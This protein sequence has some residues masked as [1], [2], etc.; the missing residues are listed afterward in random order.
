[1]TPP[2]ATMTIAAAPGGELD[3]LRR[4]LA[5]ARDEWAAERVRLVDAER[6][7]RD[8]M[9]ALDPHGEY[10]VSGQWLALGY[11]GPLRSMG[12]GSQLDQAANR[13][14]AAQRA[15]MKFDS[16]RRTAER[17]FLDRI[18]ALE[19]P[20]REAE[21]RRG[22]LEEYHAAQARLN[23][24]EAERERI[25]AELTN[26]A[27]VRE[28]EKLCRKF[29][30][31]RQ[32]YDQREP[33]RPQVPAQYLHSPGSWPESL[34]EKVR[35]SQRLAEERDARLLAEVRQALNEYSAAAEA[36]IRR[37]A[38]F[39]QHSLCAEIE[40]L[41]KARDEALAALTRDAR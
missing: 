33:W 39:T 7:A 13:F 10:C 14:G 9:L 15:L 11:Q 35:A 37:Q 3:T 38:E 18:E 41:R 24:A 32:T 12:H 5:A 30:D 20:L 23:A 26:G 8:E 19:K 28:V 25:K 27:E 2:M 6:A 31:L 36:L 40:Q 29:N 17:S 22:L 1:M 21:C 34:T 16:E 4:E